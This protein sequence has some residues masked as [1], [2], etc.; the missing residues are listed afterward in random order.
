MA[1]SS[2]EM[3]VRTPWGEVDNSRK[4]TELPVDLLIDQPASLAQSVALQSTEGEGGESKGERRE[5]GE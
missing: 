4:I 1:T 5:M 3:K 2:P